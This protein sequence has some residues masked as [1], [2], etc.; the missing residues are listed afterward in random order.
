MP[1]ACQ[2]DCAHKEGE[3]PTPPV[4]LLRDRL[5][6][7]SRQRRRAAGTLR[8]R[9]QVGSREG[10]R[11][12]QIQKPGPVFRARGEALAEGGREINPPSPPLPRLSTPHDC[13]SRA[14]FYLPQIVWRGQQRERNEVVSRGEFDLDFDGLSGRATSLGGE[15]VSPVGA[16]P[17]SDGP[18]HLPVHNAHG[19]AAGSQ[20]PDLLRACREGGHVEATAALAVGGFLRCSLLL[21]DAVCQALFPLCC[22]PSILSALFLAA[23]LAALFLILAAAI[24]LTA[25]VRCLLMLHLKKVH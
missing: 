5:G 11:V 17:E 24:I 25:L 1:D 23:V 16:E 20:R 9:V 19:V 2:K 6:G 22:L 18:A 8:R 21:G 15:G 13:L 12:V 14:L 7:S 4:A 10:R 3:D